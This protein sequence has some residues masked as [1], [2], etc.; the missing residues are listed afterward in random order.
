LS[1]CRSYLRGCAGVPYPFFNARRDSLGLSTVINTTCLF[2][3]F[4]LYPMHNLSRTCE[5]RATYNLPFFQGHSGSGQNFE[6]VACDKTISVTEL[7]PNHK[8]HILRAKR[9][10]T[11]FT[12]TVVLTVRDSMED[13]AQVFLSRRYNDV[14]TDNDIEQIHSNA[15]FLRLV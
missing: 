14:V 2:F 7:D 1:F 6:G 12:L 11:R 5:N 13:P 10:S 3:Y 15:V 8:Y 9:L 4:S